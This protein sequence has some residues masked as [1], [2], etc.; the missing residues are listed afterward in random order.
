[1][2]NREIVTLILLLAALLSVIVIGCAWIITHL[3]PV[4][5]LLLILFLA[6]S[7]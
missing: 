1:M 7:G 2:M 6:A 4:A 5:H 3:K